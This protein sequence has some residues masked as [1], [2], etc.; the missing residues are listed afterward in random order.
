MVG[1]RWSAGPETTPSVSTKLE[2]TQPPTAT[3]CHLFDDWFD[4]IEIGI[5]DRVRGFIEEMIRGELDAVLARPRYGRRVRMAPAPRMRTGSLA[6]S[7]PTSSTQRVRGANEIQPGLPF[8]RVGRPLH[9]GAGIDRPLVPLSLRSLPALDQGIYPNHLSDVP[10]PLPRR[11]E[12]VGVSISSP[13]MQPSPRPVMGEGS[14]LNV[15]SRRRP[16]GHFTTRSDALRERVQ[17]P[18]ARR[19]AALH[20]TKVGGRLPAHGRASSSS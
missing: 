20:V 3:V 19:G 5:R 7:T 16:C 4:P 6:R 9:L 13:L 11:I 15:A 18:V 17:D 12:R 14:G 1:R 8:F 2:A 10:C